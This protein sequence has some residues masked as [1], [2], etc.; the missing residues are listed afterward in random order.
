[1]LLNVFHCIFSV[2]KVKQ[3]PR[4]RNLQKILQRVIQ[5]VQIPKRAV[6]VVAPAVIVVVAAVVKVMKAVVLVRMNNQVHRILNSISINNIIFILFDMF[7]L[8]KY[9]F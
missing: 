7:Y 8:C 4:K 6:A 3:N 5:K 1:M 2:V 9:N